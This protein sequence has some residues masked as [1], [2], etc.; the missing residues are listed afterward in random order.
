MLHVCIHPC[1][2]CTRTACSFALTYCALKLGALEVKLCGEVAV[3]SLRR[4]GG[5]AGAWGLEAIR[6]ILYKHMQQVA[7]R[8]SQCCSLLKNTLLVRAVMQM[9]SA[10]APTLSTLEKL[11]C[12]VRTRNPAP[13]A[14]S[15]GVSQS[16]DSA[17]ICLSHV[18]PFH[19]TEPTG[20]AACSVRTLACLE[21]AT[22]LKLGPQSK[23]MATL[24]CKLVA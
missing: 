3:N 9:H 24:V 1:G 7:T 12:S 6:T 13:R 14:R 4:S 2:L 8:D 19:G 15:A 10:E 21:L 5:G 16:Q 11:V 22:C 17:W 23:I 18:P 20:Y